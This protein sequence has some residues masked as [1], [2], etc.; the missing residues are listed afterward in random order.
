MDTLEIVLIVLSALTV[1]IILICFCCRCLFSSATDE[2]D[3]K[4]PRLFHD[5]EAGATRRAP[6]QVIHIHQSPQQL[7]KSTQLPH[8]VVHPPQSP[9][10][11]GQTWKNNASLPKTKPEPPQIH[12]QLNKAV[13]FK[14]IDPNC[15]SK[16]DA[17]RKS[18]ERD[19]KYPQEI[20]EINTVFQACCSHS[21]SLTINQS[22]HR[23]ILKTSLLR[24]MRHT[25][26]Y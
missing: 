17:E 10:N 12:P 3:I 19:S 4:Q 18:C 22:Y 23:L 8:R 6:H 1:A 5:V 21:I 26:E 20:G 9:Q 2:S 15:I 13:K 16:Q 14:H 7:A 11:L 24:P 25:E